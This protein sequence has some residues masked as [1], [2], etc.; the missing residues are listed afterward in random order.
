MLELRLESLSSDIDLK[1]ILTIPSND[2]KNLMRVELNTTI[3]CKYTDRTSNTVTIV[4]DRSHE[5][6]IKSKPS[7]TIIM[8]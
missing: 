5:D 2:A 1:L 7:T 6:C 4:K 3:I 8:I